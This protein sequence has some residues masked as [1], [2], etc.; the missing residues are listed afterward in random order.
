LDKYREQGVDER[1]IE[2]ADKM[3]ERQ[4][5]DYFNIRVSCMVHCN[6]QEKTTGRWSFGSSLMRPFRF[7][8]FVLLPHH[9]AR[10]LLGLCDAI[11]D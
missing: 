6:N 9:A 7:I 8:Q 1:G 10:L 2:I 11:S 4:S 5:D 3:D